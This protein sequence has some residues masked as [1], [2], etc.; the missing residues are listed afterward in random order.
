MTT[1]RINVIVAGVP[2][3][4][5]RLGIGLAGKIP[6]K[7]PEDMQY[8]KDTTLNHAVIMGRKTWES[9]PPKF[10]PLPQRSNIIISSARQ[11]T[12]TT[13]NGD[14]TFCT[15]NGLE[16]AL[17]YLQSA[18]YQEA[19]VIGGASLYSEV[20]TKYAANIGKVC[21]TRV[22]CRSDG[23]LSDKY[24]EFDTYFPIG[25]YM[26][27]IGNGLINTKK[28]SSTSGIAIEIAEYDQT[29]VMD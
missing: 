28:I 22:L 20:I 5:A 19:Y 27:L 16:D 17:T 25:D 11:L 12:S 21:I 9:I 8:F 1:I 18:G 6:W 24:K 2:V 10:R 3:D 29:A 26:K 7:I 23:V 4:E 13:S 14:M 15:Y